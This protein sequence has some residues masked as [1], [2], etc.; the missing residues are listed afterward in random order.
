MAYRAARGQ[1]LVE[2]AFVVPAILLSLFGVLDFGRAVVDYNALAGAARQAALYSDQN[3][4]SDGCYYPPSSTCNATLG[5]T[6]ANLL[7][8]ALASA[9]QVPQSGVTLISERR[10]SFDD[11]AT[12]VSIKYWDVVITFQFHPIT[13][14]FM[15][16]ATI[17]ITVNARYYHQFE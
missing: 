14:F 2:F 1:T 16:G 17:P 12:R 3:N 11:V 7:T 5:I 15:R 13:L 9:P 10:G 6:S 4:L 8:N